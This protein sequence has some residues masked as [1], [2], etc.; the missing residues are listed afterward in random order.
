MAEIAPSPVEEFDDEMGMTEYTVVTTPRLYVDTIM[1]TSN[2][3][4]ACFTFGVTRSPL[5]G[6]R[7][8]TDVQATLFMTLPL[9]ADLQEKLRSMFEG[10]AERQQTP[11]RKIRRKKTSEDA[12]T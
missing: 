8:I 2:G 5:G 6:N 11:K 3:E 9:A 12:S 10:L 4:M 1:L 7:A